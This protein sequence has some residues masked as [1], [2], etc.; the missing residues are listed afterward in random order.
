MSKNL[1]NKTLQIYSIYAIIILIVAAPIFYFAIKR[2]YIKEADD[3]LLLHKKEFVLYTLP[4]MQEDLIPTWNRFNRNTQIINDGILK[5]DSIYAASY[6]DSLDAEIEPYRVL[7]SSITIGNKLYTYRAK[8]NLV[9][10]EDIIINIVILFL[11][12]IILLLLG[13]FFLTKNLSVS[14]WKPFYRTLNAIENFELDKAIVPIFLETEVKEFNRLNN[15]LQHLIENNLSVYK[16]QKEFIE[17]A[18]HE[19]QTPL[20]VFQSKIDQFMQRNDVTQEQS[21]LLEGLATSVARLTRLNKNLLLLGKLDSNI[22]SEKTALS[23]SSLIEKNLNFFTEQA[24]AKNIEIEFNTIEEGK[25]L[26]NKALLEMLVNN[27]FLNA[28][29]H[30]V[31]AG[32]IYIEVG[33][34]Y[35]KVSNTGKA[36]QLNQAKLFTRFSKI[37]TSEKGNGLGLSIVK[38]IAD[39]NGWELK[40]EYE[41]QF[42]IFLIL[43]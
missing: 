8:T 29:Q 7:E 26:A 22:Y 15:T 11:L 13:L 6:Y 32:N 42:H 24:E 3:T 40:Y 36:I 34:D 37:N 18:A 41:N 4:S 39:L 23:I 12:V 5:A 20:A 31:E 33:N 35:L 21:T 38:K 2:L 16:S 30:N 17:N 14:I 10:V 25:V 9:E 19:L 43:F 27:L 1:L 28:I